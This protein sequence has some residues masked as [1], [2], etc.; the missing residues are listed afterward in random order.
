MQIP[1]LVTLSSV[2]ERNR[3]IMAKL[4]IIAVTEVLVAGK[5][6]HRVHKGESG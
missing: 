3:F 2:A 6:W 5:T 4:T 1:A